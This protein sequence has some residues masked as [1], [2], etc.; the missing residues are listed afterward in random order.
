M[1][2]GESPRRTELGR[3]FV[4]AFSASSLALV[5]AVWQGYEVSAPFSDHSF[6]WEAEYG[7]AALAFQL[8]GLSSLRV[9]LLSGLLSQALAS[10]V[11][12]SWAVGLVTPYSP[13]ET[14]WR[15]SGEFLQFAAIVIMV[16]QW[17]V[18]L[19]DSVTYR[20]VDLPPENADSLR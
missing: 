4:G 11:L 8:C 14:L 17:F 16:W 3:A 9:H 12:A 6:Q 1:P 7:V 18:V 10:L 2:F 19:R 13:L 20:R 15:A 5:C